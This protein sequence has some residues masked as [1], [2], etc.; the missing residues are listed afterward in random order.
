MKTGRL[1]I[2]ERKEYFKKL[3]DDKQN[4]GY[5]HKKIVAG[6]LEVNIM[7]FVVMLPFV[8]LF[9]WLFYFFNG[10]NVKDINAGALSSCIFVIILGVFV[11]ELI[12]GL[13]FAMFA[14]EHF[15]SVYLGFL[16]KAFAPY[17]NCI[18]PLK[19]WQYIIAILMP[20]L[21][22]GFVIS[23]VAIII[24]NLLFV[25]V[26]ITMI[27]IGGGDFYILIK[28]AF[29]RIKSSDQIIIDNPDECGCVV[30]YK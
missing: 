15:Q 5:L 2:F 21:I 12:H 30:F 28:L 29:S 7:A 11:H 13:F 9:G 26:G 25:V 19:K 18:E 8:V 27:L 22:L 14:K 23:I 3:C 17:C 1:S 20:T 6:A 4:Q 10:F 24:G 16:W